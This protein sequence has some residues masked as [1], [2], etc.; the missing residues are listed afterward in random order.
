[1]VVIRYTVCLRHCTS[2]FEKHPTVSEEL[3]YYLKHG[4]IVVKPQV[5]NASGTTA[6]FNDGSDMDFDIIVSATG[7]HLSF[8]FL[9][10]SLVRT[11]GQNLKCIG[12]CVYPD[13]KGLYFMG[14][15]QARGGI[16]SLASAFF[17]GN[18]RPYSA[19]RAYRAASRQ[20][21]TS[22]GQHGKQNASL[23]FKRDLQLGSKAHLP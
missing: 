19:G 1:M 12:H 6:Y 15:Q 7:Y 5:V 17:K 8:P 2:P 22:H 10:Q 23:R 21:T 4:R 16:G 11:E 14:W 13:Y 3:P 9:P 18:S 20:D